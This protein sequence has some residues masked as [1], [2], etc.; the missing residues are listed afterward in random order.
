MYKQAAQTKCGARPW[1]VLPVFSGVVL[2]TLAWLAQPAAAQADDYSLVDPPGVTVLSGT[3]LNDYSGLAFSGTSNTVFVADNGSNRVLEYNPQTRNLVRSISTNFGLSDP[4]DI[5]WMYNRRFAIVD[6]ST[7]IIHVV[8]IPNGASSLNSG[9][10]VYT[11]DTGIATGGGDGL[12]GISFVRSSQGSGN[13]EFYVV[14]EHPGPPRLFLTE[15]N[16]A[17]TEPFTL[18]GGITDAAAVHH[19]ATTGNIFVLSEESNLL[20]EYSPSGTV[21]DSKSIVGFGQPEGMAFTLDESDLYVVGEPRQFAHYERDAAP[22]DNTRP[23]AQWTSPANQSTGPAPISLAG[24][25]T[26]NVGVDRVELIIRDR[27]TGDYWNGIT[28]TW[29]SFT[30]FPANLNGAGTPSASFDYQFNP[31]SGSG[32][33]RARAFAIDTSDNQDNTAPNLQFQVDDS[34]ADNTP[35]SVSISSPGADATVGLPVTIGGQATDNVGVDHIDVIIRDLDTGLW[36]NPASGAWGSFNRFSIA[37]DAPGA[38]TTGWDMTFDPP[39]PGSVTR[40]RVRVWAVDTSDNDTVGT[41]S[42]KFSGP[43]S[44]DSTPPTAVW[45]S[46]NQGQTVTAPVTLMGSLFDNVAVSGA[47]VTIRDTGTGLWWSSVTGTWGSFNRFA[48]P[49]TNPGA[50]ITTFSYSFD[51]STGS[52]NYRARVWAIDSSANRT[53]TNVSRSF[54]IG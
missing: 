6:E 17:V 19:S 47:E 7:S 40:Y 38:A 9:N 22:P 42:R 16:G 12:E 49:A 10:V 24:T 35:P 45:T 33:Y 30:R 31:S 20:V 39:T 13:E 32:Q 34:V 26:D 52:G 18:T 23:N 50:A 25:A 27:V 4:E 3:S 51:P 46:P 5:T 28:N 48:V 21:V 54:A 29:G 14:R 11:I 53:A 2:V 36:W 1:S 41:V 43:A 37:V 8:D 44:T 15:E